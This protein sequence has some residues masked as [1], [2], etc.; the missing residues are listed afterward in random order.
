MSSVPKDSDA[1][2]SLRDPAEVHIF[3]YPQKKKKESAAAPVATVFDGA[4]G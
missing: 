1:F 3:L 2:Y 4:S